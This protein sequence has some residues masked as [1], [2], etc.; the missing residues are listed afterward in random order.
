MN[1]SHS[2]L[3]R[4]NR[5]LFHKY[6]ISWPLDEKLTI[7]TGVNGSGKTKLLESMSEYFIQQQENVLYFPVDRI[8]NIDFF[9]FKTA[10]DKLESINIMNKLCDDDYDYDLTKKWSINIYALEIYLK[11]N[12]YNN[13]DSGLYQAINFI[14]NIM[15]YG[16]N[17]IAIIDMLEKNLDM[18]KKKSIIEDLLHLPNIKKLIVATHSP[19]V[20]SRHMAHSWDISELCNIFKK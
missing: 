20:I 16:D 1:N 15:N 11:M 12:Q 18:Y 19:E 13:I 3:I 9:S 8:L 17:V 5:F 2:R 10:W 7:I 4:L 14:V 6:P